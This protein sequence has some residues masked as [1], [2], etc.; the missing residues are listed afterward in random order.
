MPEPLAHR[1]GA[2]QEPHEPGQADD[3]EPRNRHRRSRAARRSAAATAPGPRRAPGWS[4][5][6]TAPG[7]W[8]VPAPTTHRPPS[9]FCH[10]H[11][12]SS[13][14]PTGSR[15]CG[16]SPD[17]PKAPSRRERSLALRAIVPQAEQR[18][19]YPLRA[20][21]RPPPGPHA[22]PSART[23]A[24]SPARRRRP[25]TWAWPCSETTSD[26]AKPRSQRCARLCL[27][28]PGKECGNARLSDLPMPQ[29]GWPPRSTLARR[30]PGIRRRAGPCRGRS[31][32]PWR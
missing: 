13:T 18:Q 4:S 22:L 29:H 2:P 3:Q 21:G 24:D 19:C 20:A 5:P 25:C 26:A 12:A 7:C 6:A 16:R 32:G 9:S 30:A 17:A 23:R 31:A 1:D 14:P 15:C 27:T 10:C 11:W 28:L 8:C